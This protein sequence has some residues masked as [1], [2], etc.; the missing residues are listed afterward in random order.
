MS[1]LVGVIQN[2]GVEDHVE[3]EEEAEGAEDDGRHV[4]VA[5]GAEGAAAA[6]LPVVV[7]V[8]RVLRV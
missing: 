1:G 2:V 3:D 5:E 6:A 7:V 4:L 8:V